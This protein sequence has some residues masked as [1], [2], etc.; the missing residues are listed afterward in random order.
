MAEIIAKFEDSTTFGFNKIRCETDR[1]SEVYGLV[2]LF[3]FG[4]IK[5]YKKRENEF[6]CKLS[7]KALF[8]LRQ[9]SFVSLCLKQNEFEFDYLIEQL[10]LNDDVE[11]EVLIIESNY[12]G[13][14][15]SEIYDFE[16]RVEVSYSIGRDVALPGEEISSYSATSCEDLVRALDKFDR[17]VLR[18][19]D[20]I[21]GLSGLSDDVNNRKRK[22]DTSK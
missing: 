4:G 10:E 22:M 15:K 3:C 21:S 9:L 16:R 17:R 5:D 14:V 11:L 19:I 20:Y 1:N 8:K 12:C 6:N 7:S 13:I 2:E 18:G